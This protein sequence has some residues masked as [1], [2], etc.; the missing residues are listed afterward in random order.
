MA[1]Y[2]MLPDAH[3]LT[4]WRSPTGRDHPGPLPPVANCVRSLMDHRFHR[5]MDVVDRVPGLGS[6]VGALCQNLADERLAA[7][8]YGRD[9]DEG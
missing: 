4:P 3:V 5:P 9:H 1:R 7:C 6:Q 8:V 2:A